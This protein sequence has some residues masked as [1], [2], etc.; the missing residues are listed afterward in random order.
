MGNASGKEEVGNNNNPTDEHG[1]DFHGEDAQDMEEADNCAQVNYHALGGS[2]HSEL[3]GQPPPPFNPTATQF[4]LPFT[5]Q[6]PVVPLRRPGE[7]VIPRHAWPQ[8]D[9]VPDVRYEDGIPTMITWSYGGKQVALEGSWDN[10]KTRMT[11]QR[12]GKD[13]IIMKVLPSGVYQ[14]RFLVDGQ[15]TYAPD[16]PWAQDDRGN[17]YNVLDLQDYVPDDLDSIAGFEPPRSPDS[18]YNNSNLTSEDYEK[19]PP[20]V[21]PHLQMTQLN[22]PASSSAI[23]RNHSSLSRPPHVVLNHLYV[24]EAK[25]GQSV[26]ALGSTNRFKS[27]YVTVVLYKSLQR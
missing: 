13:F 3:M 21:P 8:N 16:L 26:V 12:S 22:V 7:I 5:P 9:T 25:R 6:S 14:Y 4:P 24:Q 11:L 15:W 19:E 1:F 10:W 18:S 23:M 17:A 2:S 27:K 20:F